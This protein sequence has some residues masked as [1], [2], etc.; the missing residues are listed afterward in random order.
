MPKHKT[1]AYLGSFNGFTNGHLDAV[2]KQAG[3]FDDVIVGIGVNPDKK[4]REFSLAELE[5][6]ARHVV[7]HLPNVRVLSFSG[8][9]TDFLQEQRAHVL[10]RG[11][12]GGS[13]YEAQIGMERYA[14]WHNARRAWEDKHKGV[15]FYLPAAS[16]KEFISSSLVKAVMREQGDVEGMAPAS[17]VA[18]LQA[19]RERQYPYGLTGM[20]GAGKGY[21][22]GKFRE[23]AN[24]LCIPLHYEDMDLI[25]HDILGSRP[26]ADYVLLRR[27]IG[28]T[29]GRKLVN[30][31][32]SIERS[33]LGPLLFKSPKKMAKFNAMMRGR[34]LLRLR[35][36]L[37]RRKGILLMD[38]ALLA[39][40]KWTNLVN[41]NVLV[42]DADLATRTAR[43]E[44]RADLTPEQVLRRAASQFTTEK[45]IAITRQAIAAADYGSVQVLENNGQ[46]T[47]R[48]FRAAF[49]GMLKQIDIFGELRMTG[50]FKRLGVAEPEQAYDIVRKLYG[51]D[52]RRY[53]ALSHVVDGL[54]II[55]DIADQIEDPDAFMLAWVFHD[56]VYD[57]RVPLPEGVKTSEERSADLMAEHAR[58]WGL[59]EGLIE[60][61]RRLILVTQYGKAGFEPVTNDEMLFVDLD[62][63]ILGRPP[64]VFAI[65]DEGIRY[66]YGHVPQA[67]WISDMY[68]VLLPMLLRFTKGRAMF[69][70]SLDAERLFYT[71]YF[72]ERYGQQAK[73]NIEGSLAELAR[74]G[75][76]VRNE[77]L[78]KP[79]VQ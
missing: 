13:E 51:G 48:D 62:M 26:E 45:K 46:L 63:S 34:V 50:F 56:A 39:E 8:L 43:L 59:D 12:R 36:N 19:R 17:T 15:T 53:H 31:D 55:P 69:L 18:Q 42:A 77:P 74:R 79:E 54:N 1:A 37:N 21:V 33:M 52:E 64:K 5:T 14:E 22:A 58:K 40:A 65:Y 38:S 23:I 68:S 24:E 47:D 44:K 28:K 41:H 75:N 60:R 3:I 32:G 11:L 57:T 72:S 20:S 76:I 66:E 2:E 25:P 30:G 16:G 71:P 9:F 49:D 7:R 73:E 70:Q 61:A 67:A 29:F 10:V 6:N 78:R 27:E 35:K 4:D